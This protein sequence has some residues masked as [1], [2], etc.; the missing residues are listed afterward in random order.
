MPLH[1][2]VG[3]FSFVLLVLFGL[4]LG[5]EVWRWLRGNEAGLTRGQFVR[6]LAGG[7]LLEGALLMWFLSIPLMRDRRPAE[8]LLYLLTAT[9]LALVALM[10][11]VRE[12]AFVARQYAR[13]RADLARKMGDRDLPPD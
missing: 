11:A 10:L 12:A 2:A 4:Y 1:P 6:R 5:Y 3:P 9:L 13:W 7:L 8:Q